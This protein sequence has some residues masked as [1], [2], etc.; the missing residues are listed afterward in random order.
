M[1]A[2]ADLCRSRY[3]IRQSKVDSG[4]DGNLADEIEP[5]LEFS[6]DFESPFRETLPP[7]DPC[8]KGRLFRWSQHVRPEIR[9]TR[10]WY[11]R[12]DFGHAS[13]DHESCAKSAIR[14][15]H[16]DIISY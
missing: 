13:S 1:I 12:E 2:I 3:Q 9:S 15:D 8:E 7:S 5:V 14:R 10:S 6:V 11:R 4:S 16:R